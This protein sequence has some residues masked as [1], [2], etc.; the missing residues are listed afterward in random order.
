MECT[1]EDKNG[2]EER[3]TKLSVRSECSVE[4]KNV[5]EER[6]IG[7]SGLDGVYRG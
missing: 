2:I 5:I 6:G 7:V 1:V 3:R 4:N